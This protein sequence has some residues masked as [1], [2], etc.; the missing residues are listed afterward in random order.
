[1]ENLDRLDPL[2]PH[3]DAIYESEIFHFLRTALD[4]VVRGYEFSLVDGAVAID[5]EFPR[6]DSFVDI[7]WK[8][9]SASRE[10]RGGVK[11][12]GGCRLLLFDVKA[13][14]SRFSGDT[15]YISRRLDNSHRLLSTSGFAPPTLDTSS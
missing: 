3:R 10:V 9:D 15:T 6:D 14:L 13:G 2:L 7:F 5:R 4:F 8:V 12:G 1:M 11:E